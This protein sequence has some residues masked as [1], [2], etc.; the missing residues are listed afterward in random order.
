MSLHAKQHL[1]SPEKY[2]PIERTPSK[3]GFFGSRTHELIFFHY[4]LD[5]MGR[6]GPAESLPCGIHKGQI[7][8]G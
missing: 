6:H 5:S 3:D 8:G 1:F 2:F 4:D 7:K